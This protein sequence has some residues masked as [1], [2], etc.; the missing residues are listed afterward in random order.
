M[1]YGES[2]I[3]IF[4]IN[5]QAGITKDFTGVSC[6]ASAFTHGSEIQIPLPFTDATFNIGAEYDIGSIGVEM[7]YDSENAKFKVGASAV[8]GVGFWVSIN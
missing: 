4:N 1:A 2:N 8:V 6:K 3:K 7:Y 5:E